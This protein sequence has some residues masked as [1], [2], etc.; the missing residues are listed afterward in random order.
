MCVNS[1]IDDFEN[2]F[3]GGSLQ[4]GRALFSLY[5]G[6]IHTPRRLIHSELRVY[7]ARR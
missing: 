5:R 3:G 7:C 2:V 4:K 1:E 6:D